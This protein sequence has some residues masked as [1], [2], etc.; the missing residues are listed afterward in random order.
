M[1]YQRALLALCSAGNHVIP[2]DPEY[3]TT[4]IT[5]CLSSLDLV[6]T[7]IHAH[8]S[9]AM[10]DTVVLQQGILSTNLIQLLLVEAKRFTDAVFQADRWRAALAQAGSTPATATTDGSAVVVP[11]KTVA[12]VPELFS[13]VLAVNAVVLYYSVVYEPIPEL[14]IWCLAPRQAEGTTAPNVDVVFARQTFPSKS[15]LC[16]LVE[17]SRHH[18]FQSGMEHVRRCGANVFLDPAEAT[19]PPS[20]NAVGKENMAF[21]SK[22]LL[23]QPI[24]SALGE[25]HGRTVAV[26]PTDMLH[27]VPFSAL[28][29]GEAGNGA[30]FAEMHPLAVTQSMAHL[31]LA[32]DRCQWQAENHASGP[33]LVDT[34]TTTAAV[35]DGAARES[36]LVATILGGTARHLY[37]SAATVDVVAQA[38]G[39]RPSPSCVH[40]ITP[41]TVTGQVSG[42]MPWQLTDDLKC[43]GAPGTAAAPEQPI[44][45][46]DGANDTHLH[47]EAIA[48]LP[49]VE[50]NLVVLTMENITA[51]SGW[52]LPLHPCAATAATATILL[53]EG[54]VGLSIA[55]LRAGA[56]RA[57][58]SRWPVDSAVNKQVMAALYDRLFQNH[59]HEH[60]A[61]RFPM[62]PAVQHPFAPQKVAVSLHQALLT[63]WEQ[64]PALKHVPFFWAGYTVVGLP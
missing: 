18:L 47:A 30:Y 41:G 43:A 7:Y 60:L 34:T 10:A 24:Q 8:P 26:C 22:V 52:A 37:G 36:A 42:D 33:L 4:A 58:A 64:H 53:P 15:E 62:L 55:F 50:T 45:T 6:Y 27:L 63:L 3:L 44:D 29:L 9:E 57:L 59:P 39:A 48:R 28:Q 5:D 20:P 1:L 31:Q 49:M 23:P 35:G 51:P 54:A 11:M 19:P 40:S 17:A 61:A 2:A 46:E 16:T 14:F 56:T 12:S 38:L 32:M 25:C 13:V 21:L